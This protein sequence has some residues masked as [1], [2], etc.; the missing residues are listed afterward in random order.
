MCDLLGQGGFGEVYKAQWRGTEVAVKILNPNATKSR[1]QRD[2]FMEETRVMS[3]LRHPNVVL[4]MGS[5]RH[6]NPCIV[7][8]Y[9]VLGSLYDV[10]SP[11]LPEHPQ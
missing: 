2:A 7:M 11:T 9:M 3:Q 5:C 10:R 4:F 1:E 6:P 8:E